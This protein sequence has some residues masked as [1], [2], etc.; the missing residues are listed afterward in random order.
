MAKEVQRKSSLAARAMT[1]SALSD[2]KQSGRS[3]GGPRRSGKRW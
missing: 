3:E 1:N 2:L